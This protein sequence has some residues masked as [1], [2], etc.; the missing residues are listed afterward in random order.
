MD[1]VSLI[2]KVLSGSASNNEID[3]LK[4]WLQ[5]SKENQI[6]FENLKLLWT[7]ETNAVTQP[8]PGFFLGLQAIQ[9]RIQSRINRKKHI[10]QIYTAIALVAVLL[11]TLIYRKDSLTGP[12][13]DNLQFENA[14][15][16]TIISTL[17]K[18]YSI[19]ILVEKKELLACRF[20][21]TF[22][23]ISGA[24]Q[25]IKTISLALNVPYKVI[26]DSHIYQFIGSECFEEPKLK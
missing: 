23:H 19:E 2:N 1:T 9:S 25:A 5:R 22:C 10:V 17:Q 26:P 16:S 12:E 13:G 6:E 15:L 24:E 8:E 11:L 21:G 14:T 3:T 7:Q 18:K 4:Q 20:T